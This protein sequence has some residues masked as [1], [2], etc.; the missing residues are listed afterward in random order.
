MK[1]FVFLLG[2]PG[3][4]KSVVYKIIKEILE[5]KE[6][7]SP[8]IDDF[9]TLKEILARDKEFKRHILKDGGF[10]VTD[11]TVVDEALSDL[12]KLVQ[13][14]KADKKIIFIEFARDNYQHAFENFT[15]DVLNDSLIL[16]LYSTFEE[17]YKRNVA[18]F[19][20]AKKD[21]HDD[22]IVPLDLMKTYYKT[23]DYEQVYLKSK[24]ELMKIVPA[25]TIVLDSTV[26]GETGM[27]NLR[28]QVEKEVMNEL[29]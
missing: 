24:K 17:C 15:R 25:K 9:L 16:Y 18:R 6:I 1:H 11:W 14:E 26:S 29:F 7:Y 28:K 19:Q 23:D 10:A 3:C 27:E 13:K 21:G 22:H 12:C 5:K 4:G 2:R 20:K 8:R